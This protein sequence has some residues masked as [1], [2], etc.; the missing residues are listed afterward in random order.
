VLQQ[1]AR[2]TNPAVRDQAMLAM[3]DDLP[4][5]LTGLRAWLRSANRMVRVNAAGRILELTN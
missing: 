5:D 2:D 3:I 4:G 1:L